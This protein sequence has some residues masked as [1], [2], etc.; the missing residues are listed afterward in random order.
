MSI[1]LVGAIAFVIAYAQL[2]SISW[3][4]VLLASLL[5]SVFFSPAI[6]GF[7]ASNAGGIGAVAAMIAGG[8]AALAVFAINTT[9]GTHI[10]TID[11]FA[12]LLA[13]A[14]AMI[15]ANHMYPSTAE[16]K[17]VAELIS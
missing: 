14:L 2:H 17:A 8:V 7:F 12:G 11:V 16:E 13:S 5:A 10:F 3:L 1:L 4:V 15:I 6:F 9:L